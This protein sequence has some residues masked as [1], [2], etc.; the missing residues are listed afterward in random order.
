[1]KRLFFNVVAVFLMLAGGSLLVIGFM[2]G[3][4]WSMMLGAG[5]ALLAGVVALLMQYG[6]FNQ[7]T[8]TVLGIVFASTALL[9]AYR[10]YRERHSTE[11]VQQASPLN[12]SSTHGH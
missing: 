10:N 11:P 3:Q 1:M 2:E 4:P 12:D 6:Y 5:L 8:G 9:L 7:R